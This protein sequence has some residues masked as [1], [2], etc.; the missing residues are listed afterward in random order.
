M[1]AKRIHRGC[2]E[3][4]MYE[5]RIYVLPESWCEKRAME[6][7][8]DYFKIDGELIEPKDEIG[9]ALLKEADYPI[10]RNEDVKWG[11]ASVSFVTLQEPSFTY[12]DS[13]PI[14]PVNRLL[15]VNG[16][17]YSHRMFKMYLISLGFREHEAEYASNRKNAF[18]YA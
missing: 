9:E 8:S 2:P 4:G 6:K 7:R 3:L 17:D 10:F 11:K 15:S 14:N 12:L 5:W 1:K 16:E 13:P 18:G